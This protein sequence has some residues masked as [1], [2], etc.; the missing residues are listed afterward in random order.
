MKLILSNQ[1]IRHL[2]TVC[3]FLH[4]YIYIFATP[5]GYESKGKTL[6]RNHMLL[7]GYIWPTSSGPVE[8]PRACEDDHAKDDTG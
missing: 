6:E 1:K 3:D 2:L 5:H 7:R 4:I 8:R